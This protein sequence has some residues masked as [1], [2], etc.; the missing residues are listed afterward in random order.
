[1]VSNFYIYVSMFETSYLHSEKQNCKIP[2]MFKSDDK[3]CL[4]SGS[5]LVLGF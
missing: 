4:E 2:Y 1:M 3:S 5:V